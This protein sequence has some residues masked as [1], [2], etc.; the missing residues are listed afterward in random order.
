MLYGDDPA[1]L[2]RCRRLRLHHGAGHLARPRTIGIS[3]PG[4]HEMTMLLST[5]RHGTRAPGVRALVGLLGS[6]SSA[7]A[8]RL[9]IAPHLGI[10]SRHPGDAGCVRAR[11]QFFDDD[12]DTTLERSSAQ[13]EDFTSGGDAW[14]EYPVLRRYLAGA[15]RRRELCRHGG[16]SVSIPTDGMSPTQRRR[17]E[18]IADL[19]A[20]TQATRGS[21]CHDFAECACWVLA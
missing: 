7:P 19:G 17:S 11:M 10:S 15:A 1:A 21:S 16:R 9:S 6:A 2:A 13:Q 5:S 20:P 12:P 8:A 14:N 18:W 3:S 4:G